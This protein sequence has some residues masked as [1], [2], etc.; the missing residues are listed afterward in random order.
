MYLEDEDIR[1]FSELWK[2]E[3]SETL[4]PDKARHHASL[5][6]ELYGLLARP[7]PEERSAPPDAD[8]TINSP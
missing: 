3:F 7:L 8:H 4:S 2:K 1:E 5:L 6:L